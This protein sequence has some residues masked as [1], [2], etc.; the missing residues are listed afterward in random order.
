VESLALALDEVAAELLNFDGEGD[1]G[2]SREIAREPG[3]LG[4]SEG[5]K[6]ES[7]QNQGVTKIS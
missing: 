4:N 1:S 5:S 3:T 2:F 7:D 6:G